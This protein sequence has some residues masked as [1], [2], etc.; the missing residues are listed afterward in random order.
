MCLNLC[1]RIQDVNTQIGFRKDIQPVAPLRVQQ[2]VHQF[3][4]KQLPLKS[5]STIE[6]DIA[7]SFQIV[8]RLCD[9]PVR[10]QSGK[11]LKTSRGG[12]SLHL[13]RPDRNRNTGYGCEYPFGGIVHHHRADSCL[14]GKGHNLIHPC[15]THLQN[16]F[17]CFPAASGNVY[18]SDVTGKGG[19][20]IFLEEVGNQRIEF[21]IYPHRLQVEI[22]GDIRPDC[23][24]V[25]AQ[26]DV[27]LCLGER[28]PLFWG[29]FVKM[30]IDPVH[31]TVLPD[32]LPRPD[33]PNTLH[34]GNIVGSVSADCQHINHLR[35]RFNAVTLTDFRRTENLI[36][37]TGLARF[38]LKD[39]RS[40][41][42][43]VILVRSDH[44]HCAAC[45]CS[46]Y[47]HG[48]D[49]I[50]RLISFYHQHRYPQCTT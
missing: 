35:R 30:G 24:K 39:G 1:P 6:K 40:H 41:Q 47:R 18:M 15:L 14:A 29:E 46:L 45:L 2:V 27:T 42:L 13:S 36:L 43:A 12:H 20:F 16:R 7:L 5:L 34:S 21:H 23:H 48:S 9:I 31:R 8:A 4:V 11:I 17:F 10:E 32:E 28:L 22:H 33:F 37:T 3:N 49:D 50:V 26:G 19:K 44:I 38:E 25:T